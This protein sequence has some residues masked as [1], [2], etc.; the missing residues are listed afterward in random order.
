MDPEEE[1]EPLGIKGMKTGALVG[2]GIRMFACP[3][4]VAT[5]VREGRGRGGKRCCRHPSDR[6]VDTVEKRKGE[7]LPFLKGERGC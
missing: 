1:S 3:V 7:M 4:G 2:R 5:M 6:L